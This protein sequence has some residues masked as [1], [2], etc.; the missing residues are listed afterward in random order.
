MNFTPGFPWE[1]WGL[2]PGFFGNFFLPQGFVYP[3]FFFAPKARNNFGDLPQGFWYPGLFFPPKAR[4]WGICNVIYAWKTFFI[5]QNCRI[6]TN[7]GV[8]IY[9]I[10]WGVK[11]NQTLGPKNISWGV[12]RQ[13]NP[14]VVEIYPRVNIFVSRVNYTPQE[15]WGKFQKTMRQIPKPWGKISFLSENP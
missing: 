6:Q 14:G 15:P 3:G 12:K 9:Q 8:K 7:H 5:P 11:S 2:T 13:S 10:P 1:P 4:F